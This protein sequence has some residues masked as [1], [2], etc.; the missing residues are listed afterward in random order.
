MT[1][2]ARVQAAIE[3]LDRIARDLPAEQVLTNWARAARYAGSGDRAAV[4][5][6]V[7]GVLR[8]R[9]SASALGGGD[10]G[11]ALMLGYLRGAGLDPLDYFTGIGHAPAALSSD[12]V[13]SLMPP[14][15]LPD[16]VALDC[17]DW[18]EGRLRAALGDDFGPVMAAQ[19]SRAP[20][21]L[22]ANS[23]RITRPDAI[24]HLAQEGIEAVAHPMAQTALK[25]VAGESRIR[26][27]RTYLEG[28]VEIQDAASQALVE[29]LPL[30][31]GLR[32]LDYCAGG[33]GK[34][35]AM[36]A[37]ARLDLCAHDVNPGR[38]RDLPARAA[39]ADGRAEG[40]AEGR[41]GAYR[42]VQ[43]RLADR[44]GL[45]QGAYDLVLA[46]APCSG[47]G[48]WRRQPE[49]KWRLTPEALGAH[50]RL[51]AKVLAQAQAH[52][53]PGGLLAYATCSVL[54][55]ENEAVAAEFAARTGWV[56]EDQRRLG[57]MDGSDAFFLATFRA[58]LQHR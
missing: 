21:F 12:E 1:P 22:R 50:A 8:Q 15:D 29:A 40:R 34:T 39:R 43:V 10:S 51:Q 25:V 52:V 47:S 31:D 27:A 49:A 14:A 3:L 30:I 4:R 24:A 5:D 17:P 55:E 18:L 9:R 20:V 26:A 23:P 2:A 54:I 48:T 37:R 6:M 53:A 36:A 57:P 46:D 35:L 58:P 13:R 41:G 38:M 45:A 56:C 42:G 33:G 32:V 28:L 44:A 16:L 7:Y 19:R 11:R